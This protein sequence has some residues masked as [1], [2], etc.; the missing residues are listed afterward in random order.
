[1]F[2]TEAHPVDAAALYCCSAEK[3]THDALIQR[4]H[5]N[6]DLLTLLGLV[7]PKQDIFG[8][9]TRNRNNRKKKKPSSELKNDDMSQKPH[10]QFTSKVYA[11][12]PEGRLKVAV[13][14]GVQTDHH[15]LEGDVN[16]ILTGVSLDP[17]SLSDV[18][19][20][21]LSTLN[22]AVQSSRSGESKTV[23]KVDDD[24]VSTSES[25]AEPVGKPVTE[26]QSEQTPS[27]V[28]QQN[29]VADIGDMNKLNVKG[30]KIGE[31]K[32]APHFTPTDE[33]YNEPK[34]VERGQRLKEHEAEEE[35]EDEGTSK[36]E[37][38]PDKKTN[39]EEW[40]EENNFEDENDVEARLLTCP[41]QPFYS[42]LSLMGEMFLE[43][44]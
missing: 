28:N 32:H 26:S 3:K 13:P 19:D 4:F 9:A 10:E 22:D 5:D 33:K 18:V 36:V 1:M 29:S 31:R 8:S 14:S 17:G 21:I 7:E 2:N 41:S 27:E 35:E 30:P 23:E 6:V 11:K 40:K 37:E 42:R 25:T 43:T 34:I 24:K 12:A 16:K 44:V 20:R 39:E 15:P 38:E